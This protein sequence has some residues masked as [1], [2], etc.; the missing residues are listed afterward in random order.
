VPTHDL[1]L[2]GVLSASVS[3]TLS[4]SLSLSV[5]LCLS[6]SLTLSARQPHLQQHH[7]FLVDGRTVTI[8]TSEE[9]PMAQQWAGRS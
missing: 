4:L 5:S 6:L 2:A 8:W 9:H 7:L 1:Q 3:L